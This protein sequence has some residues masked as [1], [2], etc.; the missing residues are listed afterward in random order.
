MMTLEGDIAEYTALTKV[1][2]TTLMAF[3][4]KFYPKVE[5]KN[6]AKS[7]KD[8]AGAG[9]GA[10]TGSPVDPKT[11]P[12]DVSPDK[13]KPGDKPAEKPGDKPAEKPGD[14]PADKTKPGDKPADKGATSGPDKDKPLDKKPDAD[15]P[16]YVNNSIILFNEKNHQIKRESLQI[17]GDK[18]RISITSVLHLQGIPRTHS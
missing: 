15:T 18:R 10:T 16:S 13:N 8:K 9:P 7:D 3:A 5:K 11:Q 12:K 17:E 1:D 14:K 4:C 6:K 2:E